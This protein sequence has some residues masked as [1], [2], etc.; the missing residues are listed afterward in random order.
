MSENDQNPQDLEDNKDKGGEND[1]AGADDE[2]ADGA[3]G[4]G[5]EGKDKKPDP[6]ENRKNETPEDRVARLRRQ[7]SRAEKDAG[8]TK[9]EKPQTKSG[10]F[11]LTEKAYLNSEGIKGPEEHKLA[12]E[13]MKNTGKSLDAV[14]ES[15][16]FQA[17]LKELRENNKVADAT[18]KGKNNRSGQSARDSVEYWIAK[19]E[20]PPADQV[21]LRRKVVN[22]RI[23]S[24]SSGNVFTNTPVVGKA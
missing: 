22:A 17:E 20:L 3:D 21:E 9:D 8:V 11:G 5:E 18:P 24:E 16:Y 7:L 14:I 6:K 15:K 12:K 19:G 23:K 10:E 4:K 2:G 1:D 13:F